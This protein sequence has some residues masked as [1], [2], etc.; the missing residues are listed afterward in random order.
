MYN[1][2]EFRK[3]CDL[4]LDNAEKDGNQD[5]VDKFQRIKKFLSD[6]NCFVGARKVFVSF[7]LENLGYSD[8]EIKNIYNY[9]NGYEMVE[10][11]L[12]YVDDNGNL[13][14]YETLVNPKIESYY[15]FVKGSIFK[16]NAIENDYYSLFDDRWVYDGSIQRK[17]DDLGYDYDS[18]KCI[19]KSDSLRRR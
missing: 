4:L 2:D 1:V 19:V 12:E 14:Q 3:K 17:I 8:D 13:V 9:F 7:V 6:D 15:K 5:C 16:Y 18:I 11:M 10:G